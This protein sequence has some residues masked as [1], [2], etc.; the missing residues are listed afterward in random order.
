MP[1]ATTLI[2]ETVEGEGLRFRATVRDG[3]T[4]LVDSGRG[5][6]APSPVETLLVALASCMGMD[7]ISIM[8]KQRQRVTRYEIEIRGERRADHP[9]AFT[10]LE[11][12]HRL[13]GSA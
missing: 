2:L 1:D 4:T 12:V 9:R 5:R 7:V 3:H 6:V 11:L 10:R 8:R 13:H